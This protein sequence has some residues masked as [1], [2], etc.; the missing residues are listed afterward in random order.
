VTTS[1][2]RNISWASTDPDRLPRPRST[3][4]LR[5]TRL[6]PA[7]VDAISIHHTT[8]PGL[9]ASATVA[10]EITYLRAI[11]TYHRTSRGLDAIGYQI[12]AFASGRIYVT[13]PLDRYGAAVSLQND[14]TISIAMPGDFTAAPPSPD[15]IHAAAHAI[16]YVY[17]YLGRQVLVRPHR[18]WRGTACPG[19]TW[20]TWSQPLGAQAINLHPSSEEDDMG[21]TPAEAARLRTVEA[22]A[23]THAAA[24]PPPPPPPP[25][26]PAGRTYTVRASDGADGLSG[27]AL[28]QLGNA[29]RWPEIA[30]INGLRSPYTIHA[31]QVLKLP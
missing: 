11:D 28:R 21:M 7:A 16:A 22:Q 15:H 17:A 2:V 26:A 25:P 24:A 27:I 9:H 10:Q 19:D 23:H 31:G 5:Y 14:H 13:A 1:P 6:T 3:G 4:A 12:V 30:G 8:G 20:P 18:Y 29:A